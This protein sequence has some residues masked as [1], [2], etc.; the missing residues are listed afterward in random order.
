MFQFHTDDWDQ[1]QLVIP[2][3]TSDTI[4]TGWVPR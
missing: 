4:P 2:T 1:S 3:N